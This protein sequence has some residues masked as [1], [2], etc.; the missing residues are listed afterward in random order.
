VLEIQPRTKFDALHILFHFVVV[1]GIV[2][3]IVH[4]GVEK[5]P[6]KE[7]FDV[8]ALDGGQ[9]CVEEPTRQVSDGI[10]R[11]PLTEAEEFL[12][13]LWRRNGRMQGWTLELVSLIKIEN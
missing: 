5:G 7:L 8:L 6:P 9:G 4:V 1:G 3:G 11:T 12:T 13:L 10:L 2:G